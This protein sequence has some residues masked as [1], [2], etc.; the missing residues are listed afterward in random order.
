[1]R[2]LLLG[3]L[4]GCSPVFVS[5]QNRPIQDR[6]VRS[7]QQPVRASMLTHQQPPAGSMADQPLSAQNCLV[8][9]INSV[10]IPA[11]IDGMLTEIKVEEGNNVEKGQTIAVIDDRQALLM[12]GLKQAEEMKA[13]LQAS[14]DVNLRDAMA[15]EASARAESKSYEQMLKDR[16][17]PFWE[18]EKKRLEAERQALRV[19]LAE[20]EEKQNKTAVVAAKRE[21]EMAELE[22]SKRQ[23][24]APFAGYVETRIAHLGEWVQAGSPLVEL[25]QM[26]RLRV[27]GDILASDTSGMI[28]PGTPILVVVKLNGKPVHQVNTEIGFVSAQVNLRGQRRIWVDIENVRVGNS[29]LIMPGMEASIV[30]QA[31]PE[32]ARR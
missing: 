18:A 26:D 28:V 2:Y 21:R 29:W 8:K 31:K 16:S 25:L 9:L 30:L 24:K 22:L 23:V 11:Q 17:I 3:L 14:N 10:R 5:A 6:S 12:L 4:I 20:L 19:E 13:T 27:E 7:L 32:L 1:M 15:S